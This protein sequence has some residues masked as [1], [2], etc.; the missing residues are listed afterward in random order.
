MTKSH[1]QR[2]MTA[3][4]HALVQ[5]HG[6][7]A[8]F[9]SE[10]LDGLQRWQMFMVRVG[11]HALR[12]AWCIKLTWFPQIIITLIISQLLVNSAC[13]RC[14]GACAERWA[15]CVRSC[16]D[17]ASRNQYGCSTPRELTAAQK[18]CLS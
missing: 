15:R 8:T 16:A 12:R 18:S 14:C 7:F 2:T 11:V 9:I 3:V 10:P 6:T 1:V 5:K 4:T 17:A 13:M